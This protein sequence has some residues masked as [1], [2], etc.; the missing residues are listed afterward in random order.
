MVTSGMADV[1][2]QYVNIDDCWM[3]AKREIDRPD[4]ASARSAT[5]RATSCPNKHF[6][7]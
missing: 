3:N 7:T 5:P 2:Y 6:P 4:C 1:G